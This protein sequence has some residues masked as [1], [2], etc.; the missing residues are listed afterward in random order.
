MERLEDLIIGQSSAIRALRK[1]IELVAKSGASVLISG[2][3]GAG[4]ELVAKAI[5]NLSD[6]S[7]NAYV[8]MNCGAIPAELIESELFGHEKGAFTGAANRRIGR[9]EEADGGTIFLDEI[10][11]MP[12]DMQVKLLRVLEDGI[13]CRVGSNIAHKTNVRVISATHQNLEAAIGERRFR[14]DL[15]FRLGIIPILVPSLAERTEDLPQLIK[16]LQK[17]Y[18]KEQHVTFSSEAMSMLKQYDWPGNVRELRNVVARAQILFAGQIIVP[19]MVGTLISM[20]ATNRPMFSSMLPRLM[21]DEICLDDDL[22]TA[23]HEPEVTWGGK[24]LELINKPEND[25]NYFPE[26]PREPID[27][28]EMIEAIELKSIEAALEAADG[29][30]SQA[31]KLLSL[32]RTTMV[33]KMRKYGITRYAA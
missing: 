19:N 21:D 14:Q 3:S 24:E 13:I 1:M 31:A 8:P 2:P 16:H 33:E 17:D 29:V 7:G 27:L 28:K 6:R 25:D 9:F 18:A 32:K 12:Y 5:H 23:K 20:T 26:L 10:G 22:P 4:K 11:D 15:Y 30:I